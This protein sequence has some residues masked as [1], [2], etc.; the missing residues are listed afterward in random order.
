MSSSSFSSTAFE[1]LAQDDAWEHSNPLFGTGDDQDEQEH[2]GEADRDKLYAVLNLERNASQEDIQRAYRRLAAILH[3]DRHSARDPSLKPAADARFAELQHAFEVL[4]DPHKRAVYDELGDE[5]L[6]TQWEVGVRGK[7]AQ[8]LR[9]EYERLNRQQLEQNVEQ[10]V[11]SKGDLTIISDARVA[12]LSPA[13][14]SRLTGEPEEDLALSILDR[15]QTI[16]AKQFVLK[17]SFNTPITPATNVVIT[18]QLLARN[19][20]GGG[21]LLFK[22]QHNPSS[23]LQLE[24]GTTLLRPRALNLKSTYS[25]SPDTFLRLETTPGIRNLSSPPKFTFVLGR[26]IYPQTTGTL[27]LRSGSWAIGNWGRAS[28]QPYSDSVMAVGLNHGSGW[29]VEA[30]SGVFS[31]QVSVNWGKTVGAGVKVTVGGVVTSAGA[32]SLAVGADRR[33][34][35]NWKVGGGL[36]VAANGAMLVKLRFTRLGQRLNFPLMITSGFDARLFLAFTV[37]PA[38]SIVAT[39]YWFLAP[40]QRRKLSGKLKELRKEHAA[41]ILEQRKAALDAQALLAEHVKKRVAEEEAKGGLIIVG[42]V[43]GVLEAIEGD[44][45]VKDEAELRWLDVT[46]PLQSLLPPST[47]QLII[48]SGRSKSSLLGFYDPALGERKELRIRY[49]FKG[50]MHEVVVGDRD[51]VALP[52]RGHLREEWEG[53]SRRKR[54][55]E[56]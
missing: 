16:Q 34:T 6:K 30:S 3:P 17:H 15:L 4:S 18:S 40:R 49:R 25:P 47:S 50:K 33:V 23:K 8:E 24:I 51:A 56:D 9:A 11:R 13:E 7:S 27:T 12:F 35:E 53:E 5:G 44:G 10:L 2:L 38:A 28:L 19:G 52:M 20:A 41:Y 21:N 22:L 48:P 43:Y 55:G 26:R 45:K 54:G 14:L 36:D 39:N 37:I 46:V 42:A 31:R 1:R 32:M 29:A